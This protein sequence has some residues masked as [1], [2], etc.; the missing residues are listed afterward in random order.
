MLLQ[1]INILSLLLYLMLYLLQGLVLPIRLLYIFKRHLFILP[2]SR[3]LQ[4]LSASLADFL[5]RIILLIFLNGIIILCR[6]SLADLAADAIFLFFI[7]FF[8]DLLWYVFSIMGPPSLPYWLRL[9]FWWWNRMLGISLPLHPGTVCLVMSFTFILLHVIIIAMFIAFPLFS[10][11]IAILVMI[12]CILVTSSTRPSHLWLN[13]IGIILLFPLLLTV[14]SFNTI[15]VRLLWF[16]W[17]FSIAYAYVTGL[18]VDVV[19]LLWELCW[20]SL[21]CRWRFIVSIDGWVWLLDVRLAASLLLDHIHRIVCAWRRLPGWRCI[22]TSWRIRL[23][24]ALARIPVSP[25]LTSRPIFWP[26]RVR[27]LLLLSVLSFDFELR[28]VFQSFLSL[29]HQLL[30]LLVFSRRLLSPTGMRWL[31]LISRIGT[32]FSSLI[33]FFSWV[34]LVIVPSFWLILHMLRLLAFL[35][36]GGLVII[37]FF[38]FFHLICSSKILLTFFDRHVEHGHTI[39]IGARSKII[40][41]FGALIYSL[42][43]FSF[44]RHRRGL[45]RHCYEFGITSFRIILTTFLDA[46]KR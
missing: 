3:S 17:L 7:I 24:I 46:F 40:F 28:C 42:A 15:I 20:T 45:S 10:L 16:V 29:S 18:D 4:L 11:G 12:T 44:P 26:I 9:R 39:L 1:Y 32:S 2:V 21:G 14:K 34:L 36:G 25:I 33:A 41:N 6:I 35:L 37:Y 8:L 22:S 38:D 13:F 31:D 43:G 5:C 23:G 27:A 19:V 30:F